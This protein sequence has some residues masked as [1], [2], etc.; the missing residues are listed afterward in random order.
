M[1]AIQ[2]KWVISD[3]SREVGEDL[4]IRQDTLAM[5]EAITHNLKKNQSSIVA[6]RY[7]MPNST[8]A[9]FKTFTKH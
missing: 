3:L 4:T 9:Y 1:R 7:R 2:E 5:D 8:H 6:F